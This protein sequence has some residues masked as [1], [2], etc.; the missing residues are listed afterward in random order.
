MYF[1]Q[2]IGFFAMTYINFILRLTLTLHLL[3]VI[4]YR[5]TTTTTT[6]TTIT[7][8]IITIIIS[9]SSSISSR[10]RSNIRSSSNSIV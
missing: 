7:I 6:T 10:R 1:L 5:L 3:G 9:S 2:F 8:V 4:D